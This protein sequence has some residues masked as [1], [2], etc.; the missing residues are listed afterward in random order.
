VALYKL[1]VD[2]VLYFKYCFSIV[3]QT[4][5]LN[6]ALRPTKAFFIKCC[7]TMGRPTYVKLKVN[8]WR[9]CNKLYVTSLFH[10]V[11][12]YLPGGCTIN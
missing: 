12:L 3:Y 5:H 8:W 9:V 6:I 2:G 1:P 4:K 7:L 11:M 10:K